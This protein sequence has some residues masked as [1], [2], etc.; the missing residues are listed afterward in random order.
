MQQRTVKWFDAD[1]PLSSEAKVRAKSEPELKLL[2]EVEPAHRVF[3]DNL[4]ETFLRR[5]PPP[6]VPSSKLGRFWGDVFIPSRV[7]W[8]SFLESMLWHSLVIAAICLA[9]SWMPKERVRQRSVFRNSSPIY[10][11]PSK[12]FSAARSSPPRSHTR[13][14]TQSPSAEQKAMVVPREHHGIVTPPDLKQVLAAARPNLGAPNP[15]LPA[16][17]LS[18]TERSRLTVPAGPTA[19]VAPAPGVNQVMTGRAGLP[20]ASAVGPPPS[21]NQMMSGRQGTAGR[22]GLPQASVVRPPPDVAAVSG[23][24]GIAGLGTGATAGAGVIAPP[25]NV[26]TGMRRG[27]DVNIG[28]S[29]VVGPA[30]RLPMHEQS[31]GSG[32]TYTMLGN[33]SGG[34]SQVVPPPPSVDGTGIPDGHARANSLSSTG[35]KIVPPAP[36]VEG[37]ISGGRGSSLAG[38]GLKVVPP[39]PTVE[40]AGISSGRGLGSS[41]SGSGSKVVPPAPS[42]DGTGFGGRGS[43]NSLS[44]GGLKVVRPAPSVESAGIPNGRGRGSSLSGGSQVVPPP[45]SVDGAGGSGGTGRGNSLYGGGS[46]VVPP[47]PIVD[48][49]GNGTGGGRAGLMASAGSQ[50]A[51]PPQ[52]LPGEEAGYGYAGSAD[53]PAAPSRDPRAGMSPSAVTDQAA[54]Q[55]MPLRLIGLAL[56]LPRSSYFSNYEVFLAEIRQG[57][58]A[59]Q[60][61]KLV[62]TYLPYQRRLSEY[63]QSNAR[64]Y[65]LRV[66]R[67][68]TCDES[69]LQMS[70]PEPD[71][72]GDEPSSSDPPT[73]P[74]AAP[75]AVPPELSSFD[76]KTVLP[77]Y[78]TTADDYRNALQRPH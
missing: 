66:R 9:P 6:A 24:R 78:R 7:P 30:P 17:P 16:V 63:V 3:L 62:Y 13:A 23:R 41:L 38:T 4:A 70:Q 73:V 8:S 69:I 68:A 37:G 20:Q 44:N 60:L 33:N 45:P 46:G 27:G 67:D 76:Q 35:A 59:T 21:V 64:V 12:S 57:K 1:E 32:L 55:E 14:K 52:L 42:V 50:A 10:Y 40:S 15:T 26:P 74:P 65:K 58:E 2:L 47:P 72:P 36:S 48:G 22:S 61:V 53:H 43:G 19:V 28:H 29:G 31:A 34:G 54:A 51:L 5:L 71:P 77:C 25:P 39:A 75:A 18:A 11:T 49:A 56:A